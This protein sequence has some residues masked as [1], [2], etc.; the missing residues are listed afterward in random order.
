LPWLTVHHPSKNSHEFR[1]VVAAD[2][3]PDQCNA[4]NEAEEQESPEFPHVSLL[5]SLAHEFEDILEQRLRIA[6]KTPPTLRR[7]FN[8]L[9]TTQIAP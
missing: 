8:G 5:I 6:K 7:W 2:D 9:C 3:D 1:D 4:L